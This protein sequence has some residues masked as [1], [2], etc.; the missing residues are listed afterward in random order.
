MNSTRS[1]LVRFYAASL[2]LHPPAFRAE[3]GTEMQAV[4]EQALAQQ[5]G[6]RAMVAFCLREVRDLPGAVLGNQ[7]YLL[8]RGGC[9]M[10]GQPDLV[11]SSKWEAFWGMLPFLAF[12]LVSIWERSP[13]PG[14]AI[15][16]FLGFYLLALAGLLSGWVRG[17]PLWSF[18]YLGW[19]LV[20]AW[21]WTNMRTPGFRFFGQSILHWGWSIWLPLVATVLIALLWTR[22]LQ[23]IKA[24]ILGIWRDWTCLSLALDTFAAFALL[25]Y[26]ENHHPYVLLF[27]LASTLTAS[28]AVWFFL[29]SDRALRRMVFLL[30]GFTALVVIG[31]VCEATWDFNAYYH[32]SPAPEPWYLSLLRW[33][34]AFIVYTI[35]LFF[36]GILGWLRHRTKL[37]KG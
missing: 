22:S 5:K 19:S 21:W 33:V 12:G 7:W 24:L 17:F 28:A 11:K 13:L 35:I 18:S 26:D 30:A 16:P 8:T 27:L 25:I 3:F 23:P 36:P 34:L 32:F 10:S 4:F 1:R 2:H 29:R 14:S 31:G 20:F 9:I 37:A 15:Y 6:I